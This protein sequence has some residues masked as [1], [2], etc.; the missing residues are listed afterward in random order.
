MTTI[1]CI[2]LSEKGT[3]LSGR[4][5]ARALRQEAVA[6]VL[7]GAIAELDFAGVRCVSD[8]FLDEL[9]AVLVAQRGKDWFR[10]NVRVVNID[11]ITLTDLVAA[12]RRRL[13]T[14]PVHSV[15]V[16]QVAYA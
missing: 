10:E 3:D 5:V 16:C 12:V 11:P 13:D 9:F 6:K 8:S 4:G 15:D 1:A 2:S 7:A 14:T